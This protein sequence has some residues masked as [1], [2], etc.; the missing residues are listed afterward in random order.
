MSNFF[1]LVCG[2]ISLVVAVVLVVSYQLPNL[3]LRGRG[4]VVGRTWSNHK[5]IRIVVIVGRQDEKYVA[6]GPC[7]A[8]FSFSEIAVCQ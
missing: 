6:A 7:R 2:Q 3:D 1:F 4:G 8:S 5:Y